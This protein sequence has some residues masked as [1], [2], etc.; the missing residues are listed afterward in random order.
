MKKERVAQG[1]G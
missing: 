1:A